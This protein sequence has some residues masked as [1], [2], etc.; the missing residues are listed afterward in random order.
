MSVAE[1]AKALKSEPEIPPRFAVASWLS[2]TLKQEPEPPPDPPKPTV[3]VKA[4]KGPAV[5]GGVPDVVRLM[6]APPSQ[7]I[8]QKKPPPPKDQQLDLF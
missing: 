3:R 8:P 4:E 1:L 5:P 6:F 7:I 2:K